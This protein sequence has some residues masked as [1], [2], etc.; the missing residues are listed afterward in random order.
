VRELFR[1]RTRRVRQFGTRSLQHTQACHLVAY[2]RQGTPIAMVKE[3]VLKKVRDLCVTLAV[4]VLLFGILLAINP[5]VHD[6]FAELTSGVQGGDSF[7]PV[8]NAAY[9]ALSVGSDYAAGNPVLFWF[10]IA[11]ALLFMMMLRT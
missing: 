2:R 3:V 7:A 10:V 9:A 6:K 1:R 5:R 8:Q 4:L 11:A